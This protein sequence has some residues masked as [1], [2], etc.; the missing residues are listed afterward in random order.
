MRLKSTGAELSSNRI[1]TREESRVLHE[2]GGG[3][4]LYQ[5]QGNL[6]FATTEPI[7]RDVIENAESIDYLIL[8]FKRALTINESACRLFYQTLSKLSKLE[9]PV[10][11]TH[12]Y[13]V[14]LLRRYMKVKLGER[15]AQL[16]RAQD[17]NDLA[18]EW[19]EN[20]IIGAKLNGKRD[21]AVTP[22]HYELFQNLTKPELE[23]ITSLL[24]RRVYQPGDII[25]RQGDEAKELFFLARGS[26]S[27][28]VPVDTNARKRLA[29]FSAGMAFGEMAVIDH[30]PR[31]AA[32][33]ADSEVECDML[34]LEDF[35]LLDASHPAVKIKLL[36]NLGFSLSVRLRKANRKLS[37]FD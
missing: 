9:K 32:I 31:S 33:V 24:K 20:E 28:F 12:A 35:E 10:I 5:V 17:D 36:E 30:A 8:D 22:E 6:T 23:V 16:F 3:I 11:F 27:V 26:V 14:P 34:S 7:V 15:Y 1:R 25:I 4:K 13:H 19:C 37:V 29:T 18:L 2:F 21:F